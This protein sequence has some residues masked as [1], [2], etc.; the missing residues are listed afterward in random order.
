MKKVVVISTSF[1][2]GV[3]MPHSIDGNSK[4]Q[5]AYELGKNV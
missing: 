2:G 1:C 5:E 4:L 3:P